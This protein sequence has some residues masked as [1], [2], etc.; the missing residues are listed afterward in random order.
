VADITT[1]LSGLEIIDMRYRQLHPDKSPRIKRFFIAVQSDPRCK[2]FLQQ[3]DSRIN[4]QRRSMSTYGLKNPEK[5]CIASEIIDRVTTRYTEK[6]ISAEI[7]HPR[8]WLLPTLIGVFP[9]KTQF[10]DNDTGKLM[11]E[12][13]RAVFYGGW[14]WQFLKVLPDANYTVSENHISTTTVPDDCCRYIARS[15][16]NI[17]P[18]SINSSH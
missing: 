12:H 8:E 3:D 10:I 15:G 14:V 16:F 5:Y 11:L 17:R 18:Y 1:G 2:D 4:A 6:R 9:S 7:N 13:R